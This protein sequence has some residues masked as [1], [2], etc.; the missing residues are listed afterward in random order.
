[1]TRHE[2]D[3]EDQYSSSKRSIVPK[4]AQVGSIGLAGITG[5]ILLYYIIGMVVV[6]KIM[7]DTAFETTDVPAGASR[8]VAITA[9]VINR[10][11]DR[12]A[13][14]AND[15]FFQSIYRIR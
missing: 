1:M 8:A 2:L 12:N 11:V 15:P 4:L 7:D 14:V 13:W 9:E 10:E 6:H 5:L 3:W